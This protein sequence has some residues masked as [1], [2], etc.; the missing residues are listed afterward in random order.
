ML[1]T[2]EQERLRRAFPRQ[3]I[4]G[5]QPDNHLSIYLTGLIKVLG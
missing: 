2:D 3:F 5:Q 1:I 4:A